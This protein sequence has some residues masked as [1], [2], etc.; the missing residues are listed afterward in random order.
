M[1]GLLK[2]MTELSEPY[3]VEIGQ[4]GPSARASAG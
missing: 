1:E 3:T 4:I 2:A